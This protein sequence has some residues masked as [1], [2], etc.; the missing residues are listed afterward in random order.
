M[1]AEPVAEETA[2]PHG[3]QTHGPQPR[4]KH[5]NR[6]CLLG[7]V[8]VLVA[9]ALLT[10]V[11]ALTM[12]YAFNRTVFGLLSEE[13]KAFAASPL[14][15]AEADAARARV[16][17]FADALHRKEVPPALELTADEVNAVL[18]R[19]AADNRVEVPAQ[20]SFEGDK[21]HA[22]LSAPLRGLYLNGSGELSVGLSNGVLL[23]LVTALELNGKPAPESFMQSVRTHNLAT[24]F[25]QDPELQR[26][27]RQLE[28]VTVTNGKLK[29]T[30]KTAK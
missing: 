3:P 25:N 2:A 28:Y 6:S 24:P 5:K 11:T 1:S 30:P 22:E 15:P 10:I 14:S 12:F 27:I 16:R 20:V 7:C 26:I 29:I 19:F 9:G 18:E 8:V 17:A 13:R 21:I 23:V 4:L